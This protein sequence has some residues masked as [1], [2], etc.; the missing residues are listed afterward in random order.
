MGAVTLSSPAPGYVAG[1]LATE[2]VEGL[3]LALERVDD[4]H[5]GDSLPLGVLGV[6]DSVADHVLQ[7]DLEDAASLLVDQAGD[8]LD[9]TPPGQAADGGLG[10]PLDVVAENL[11]M[12]LASGLTQYLATLA[13]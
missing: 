5:G 9:T 13:T 1:R 11:A 2:A 4:V 6:G 7:E 8:P 10:D 12:S 3:A